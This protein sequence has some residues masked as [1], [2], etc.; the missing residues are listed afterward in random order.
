MTDR[1]KFDL[2]FQGIAAGRTAKA[3]IAEVG[4]APHAFRMALVDDADI[5]RRHAQARLAQA[6]VLAE[7]V[8]EIADS[9]PDAQRARNRIQARQWFAARLDPARWG[10]RLDLHIQ[11]SVDL[12]AVLAG[13]EGR[14][15]R[16]ACD[17]PEALPVLDVGP[18]RIEAGKAPDSQS[19][20]ADIEALMR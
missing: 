6:S 13:A 10:E 16:P 18:A 19:G 11:G 1:E 8:V 5:A 2:I 7:E 3:M 12:R 14:R 9:E 4:L 20:D 15:L 17:Q